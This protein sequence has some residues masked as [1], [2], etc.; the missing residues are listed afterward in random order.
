MTSQEEIVNKITEQVELLNQHE[1]DSLSGDTLSRIA[2]KLAAYKAGLGKHLALA[3]KATWIAEKNLKVAKAEAYK[4]L[5]REKYGSGDAKEMKTLEVQ[6]E[7]NELIEAQVMEDSISTL[8]YNVHDLIDS[9]K[10]RLINLQMESIESK[11]H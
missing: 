6:K 1:L 9:I 4:E 2:V 11:A 10:S 3:K 8:S 7:M 5:R